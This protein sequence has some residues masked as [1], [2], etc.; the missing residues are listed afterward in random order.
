[1]TVNFGNGQVNG[2]EL[3]YIVL[4]QTERTINCIQSMTLKSGELRC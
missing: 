3:L 1:M 4:I 2:N